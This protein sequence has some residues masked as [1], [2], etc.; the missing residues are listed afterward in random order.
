MKQRFNLRFLMTMLLGI[1]VSVNVM[2]QDI[3]VRGSVKDSNGEPII[4]AT[5]RYNGK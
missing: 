2:A 1:F 5:V 4:G 3:N